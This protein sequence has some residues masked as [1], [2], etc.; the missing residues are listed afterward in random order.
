[1]ALK[2][3]KLNKEEQK[4]RYE[5]TDIPEEK[6]PWGLRL[7]LETE[8]VKKLGLEGVNADDTVAIIAKC[9]VTDIHRSDG[10]G[11]KRTS[12]TLQITDMEAET[13]GTEEETTERFLKGVLK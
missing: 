11:G 8:D 7:S 1:M 3:M 10:R 4:K 6:Y 9:S 13:E 12:V 2:S 5:V